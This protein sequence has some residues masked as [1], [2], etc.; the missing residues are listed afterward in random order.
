M[1]TTR[2][3]FLRQ[4]GLAAAGALVAWPARA[5]EVAVG[6]L[7]RGGAAQKVLV[8]GAGLAGLSAAYELVRAGHD[9]TVLEARTRPGGRVYTMRE[10]FSDGLYAEAGAMFIPDTHAYTLRY[11]EEFGLKLDPY[12]QPSEWQLAY[13]RGRRVKYKYGEPA[14]WPYEL[15]EEEKR[16]GRGGLWRKYRPPSIFEELGDPAA[17]GWEVP[18]KYDEV[19]FAELIRRNGASPEAVAFMTHGWGALWGDG[20]ESVSALVVL[21]DTWHQLNAGQHYRIRGGND[22]LP[23]ALAARLA[24]RIRYG[25]QVVRV[26]QDAAGVRAHALRAGSRE[27]HAADRLVC[28]VPF[29]VLRRV[30]VSPPFSEGKRRAVEGLPYFSAARVSLQA[31]RRFWRDEGLSGFAST[32]LAIG[33]VFDMTA[34][35]EGQRGILQAYAGGPEAR[36]ITAMDEAGRVRFVL[37][38]MESVFPGAREHFEGGASK[39]WDEDPFARGASSWYRPG[40]MAELWPHVA[41]PEGRIHFAGDHTSAWIRWMNGALHSGQR[42]AREINGVDSRQ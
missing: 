33:E 29:S 24:E 8:L 16:L 17:P 21:R 4:T 39:C 22:L 2:R 35:Q 30:E 23:K 12:R 34:N 13:M 26:E 11:A 15:T 32:D 40:Q 10:P 42:A 28:A 25:T 19:S 31:R 7:K 36:R 41:R 5:Q 9:V 20:F 3:K 18:R 37:G 27:T 14:A 6:R 1:T 38:Q